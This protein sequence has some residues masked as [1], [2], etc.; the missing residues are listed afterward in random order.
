M[1]KRVLSLRL[2]VRRWAMVRARAATRL[3]GNYPFFAGLS[4]TLVA[5]VMAILTYAALY[6]GRAEEL[7]HA[8]ENSH[9]LVQ[10]IS[11]DIARNVEIYDLSLQAVVTAAQ[12]PQTWLMPEALRQRVLF[13]RAT[14][15]SNLGGAYVVDATGHVKAS[16][17]AVAEAVAAGVSFADRDYFVAHQSDPRAG[18]FFSKPYRSRLRGGVLTIGLTRRIDAPDG[19]FAGVALLGVR[20]DYFQQLLERVDLGQRGHLFILMRDGTLLASK[21]PSQRGAGASYADLPNFAVFSRRDAGT[22]TAHSALDGV[23]RIYTFAH[24]GNT[25]V[26][27]VAA[28]AVADV[29]ASWRRRS[30]IALVMTT[31]FGGAWVVVSWVLA[32]AL[33]D[34]VVAEGELLRLAVTDPLTGLANRRAFDRRLAEEWQHAVRERTPLSVLFFDIDHFKLFN[35][36]YGHAAGDEVLAFV[37]GRI[38]AG[39]RRATDLVARFGGEEFVVLLPGTTLD[40]ATRMAEK[41]RRR[42]ESD[43]LT[44]SGTH[45]GCVT[46]SAGCAS[47]DPPAGG[48]GAK[49]LIAADRLLYE[50]KE[51]GRNQVRSQQWTGDGTPPL[52]G[53]EAG[54][55]GRDAPAT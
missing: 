25:P 45:H 18:L 48:S 38:A 22:Y 15:A 39:S 40:A 21:P 44:L 43:N 8:A 13:D 53:S 37:A 3:I 7:R 9:N 26:I 1:P 27:V 47:C 29:L 55:R 14:A 34:K 51:A 11:N 4:G 52:V 49:L 30:Y 6:E 35:D 54:T 12:Q 42:I 10:L 5:T 2:L 32:F 16:Q 41:I 17:R 20:L 28:P 19:A 31:V 33:R 50:A 24:V 23:M 46:V 36:T